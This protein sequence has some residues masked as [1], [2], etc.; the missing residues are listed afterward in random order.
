MKHSLLLLC[1]TLLCNMLLHAQIP[2]K[3][4]HITGE[5]ADNTITSI[6]ICRMEADPR[7]NDFHKIPFL[8]GHFS[9]DYPSEELEVLKI[10]IWNKND[11]GRYARFFAEGD[12]VHIKFT[13]DGPAKVKASTPR[14]TELLQLEQEI[15]DKFSLVRKKLTMMEKGGLD[16]T[17][18]AKLLKQRLETAKGNGSPDSVTNAIIEE[19][20]R[21]VKADHI[22]TPEYTAI[23]K[24]LEECR[25]QSIQ[26][27]REYA[28]THPDPVGLLCLYDATQ[29]CKDDDSSEKEIIEIYQ[30]IYAGKM[31]SFHL[32]DYLINWCASRQ[33]RLGGTYFDFS[34]PDLDGK[35][36]RLSEEIKGKVALIDLWASW[37]GP[38]RRKAKSMIPV[39][40]EY[41][42][43]GFT[44][45]G[46]ARENSPE[47]M[48]LALTNDKYP[49]LNLLELRDRA[50]IWQR[51]GAG[52][53][54]GATFL[55][56]RDGT[57]LA[58]NPTPDEVRAILDTKLKPLYP[59]Q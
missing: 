38:C 13:S 35:E 58:I 3:A 52:N 56:D 28:R 39:Y 36:H 37:C 33:I 43:K 49:W 55:V 44:I 12:S 46:V 7:V 40:E 42:D 14:N 31:P 45:V 11:V 5:F 2:E 30:A 27:K 19:V 53:S 21:L 25:K 47:N 48:R 22:Y 18:E 59:I 17:P 50:K 51:Y 6:E 57:I 34:A 10:T 16:L 32:S 41:K 26:Y 29:K 8:N 24:Q 15:D 54:G 9:Y 20:E 1:T 4:T 23:C